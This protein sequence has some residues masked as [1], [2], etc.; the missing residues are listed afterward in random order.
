MRE[1]QHVILDESSN[2]VWSGLTPPTKAVLKVLRTMLPET[3]FSTYVV[4]HVVFVDCKP[5]GS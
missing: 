2:I 1:Q 4:D 5:L 3:T